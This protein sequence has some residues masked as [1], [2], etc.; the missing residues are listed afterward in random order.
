MPTDAS[1]AAIVGKVNVGRR[2]NGLAIEIALTAPI[3]PTSDRLTNPDRLV[4]DFPGCG[5]QGTNRHIPVNSGPVEEVRISLFRVQPPVTRVVIA[6]KSPLDF[7]V[8]FSGNLVVVEITFPSG[9][10]DAAGAKRQTSPVEE[11]HSTA[12]PP[13]QP[14]RGLSGRGSE[15]QPSA[16]SLQEKA[17][18]LTVEDLQGLE[19]KAEAGNPEAQT[20]LALAYHAGL[21]LKR[22]DAEALRLLHQAADRGFMAALESLGIFAEM[23]VGMEQPSPSDALDWYKKAVQQGSL[24]AA[25]NIALIYA[26]GRGVPKDPRQAVTWFRRAAEGGDAVA[27]YNLALIY[28]RGDAVSPDNKESIRWLTA[29]ADQNVVPA[30]LDLGRLYMHPPD[31][32]TPDV[33]RAISYYQKAGD[34]GSGMADVILGTIFA[35]G[36]QGK[37]DYDQSVKWYRKA[38]EQGQPDAQ[39]GL[40]LRYALGQGVPLDLDEARRLFTSA[41]E[42]GQVDAQ[43]DLAIVYEEGRG[44]TADPLLAEHFY[45]LAADQGM[46]K[47]QFRLGRLLA[48]KAES[49]ASR[50]AAY[51]WLLLAQD[52]IKESS[53]V[54]SEL[55]KFMQE[56]EIPEAE[57]EVD[58]WRLAHRANRK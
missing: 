24:D 52:S 5:L 27:Q 26:D 18:A 39:F 30:L 41:A 12:V 13:E 37:P 56:Q 11:A 50:I 57:R 51:K 46:A 8:K 6:S 15:K 44:T 35:D 53:P 3:V 42:Q 10:P 4:L 58:N 45:Q 9:G 2:P 29:A 38:A 19:D 49:R 40:G 48:R 33:G 17:K 32:T 47:A 21:L 34:L 14:G 31:S 23:G 20:T 16:Y 28:E 7:Q 36:L 1:P 25:T 22:D 43:Y 55:R 54:L